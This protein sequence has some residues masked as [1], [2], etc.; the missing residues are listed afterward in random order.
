MQRLTLII[1][2]T[3]NMACTYCYAAGGHYNGPASIMDPDLSVDVFEHFNA[4]FR[5][6]QHVL[7]F[8]GEPLVG[9]PVIQRLCTYLKGQVDNGRLDH[10]PRFGIVTNGTLI[11]Q[12]PDFLD[13]AKAYNFAVTVSM[14]GPKFLN[15]RNRPMKTGAGSFDHIVRG[16]SALRQSGIPFSIECTYTANHYASGWRPDDLYRYFLAYGPEHVILVEEMGCDTTSFSSRADFSRTML[17]EWAKLF[18]R[19]LEEWKET[20]VMKLAG[21]EQVLGAIVRRPRLLADRFC[22]GGV[23]SFAVNPE[24]NVYP[25]HILN[26]NNHFNLGHYRNVRRPSTVL[27]RKGDI[28]VC[29]SCPVKRLCRSCPAKMYLEGPGGEFRPSD[30]Q[31]HLNRISFLLAEKVLSDS[32]Q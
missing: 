7:F 17:P 28:A 27:P 11:A 1:S 21:P 13:L 22:E 9:L 14:D 30:T 3:C 15:D 12:R 24:G 5:G 32:P 10:L 16:L 29:Q 2:S 23:D 18:H 19:T 25:C 6:V 31:C 26:N 8:G 4:N 20:D